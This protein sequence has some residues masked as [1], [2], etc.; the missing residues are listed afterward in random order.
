MRQYAHSSRR[1]GLWAGRACGVLALFSAQLLVAQARPV[2]SPGAL[3]RITHTAICCGSPVVGTL[4]SIEPDSLRLVDPF[5]LQASKPRAVLPRSSVVSIDIG[6]RLGAQ[7]GE[8]ATVGL[9]VGALAGGA[10][11]FA[12]ACAHCDGDWRPLGALVGGVGGG[13][14]GLIV[15]TAVGA[16]RP[17][18]EWTPARLPPEKQ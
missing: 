14:L 16:S 12:T 13:L 5:R 11:G 2:V 4:V 7:K 9:L 6:R 8:G 15:G 10:I 3:V 18:Y 17:H 1:V